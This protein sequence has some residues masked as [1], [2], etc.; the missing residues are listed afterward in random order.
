MTHSSSNSLLYHFVRR[1]MNI[2]Q[3]DVVLPSAVIGTVLQIA[4]IK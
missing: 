4:T 3:A 1:M 2:M